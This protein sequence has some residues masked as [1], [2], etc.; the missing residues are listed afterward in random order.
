MGNTWVSEQ[1]VT[2][3]SNLRGIVSADAIKNS[4]EQEVAIRIQLWFG[5]PDGPTAAQIILF[6]EETTR[7]FI[8][9]PMQFCHENLNSVISLQFASIYYRSNN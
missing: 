4:D 5:T 3:L 2:E 1:L 9:D 7:K 6:S 8:S